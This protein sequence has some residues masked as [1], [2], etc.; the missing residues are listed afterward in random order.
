MGVVFKPEVM[1]CTFASALPHH[2]ATGSGSSTS[3]PGIQIIFCE[4]YQPQMVNI[5]EIVRERL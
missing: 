2:D 5:K 3:F 1:R 4:I